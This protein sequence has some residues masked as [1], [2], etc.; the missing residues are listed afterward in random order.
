MPCHV[1]YSMEP[2]LPFCSMI[3][4]QKKPAFRTGELGNCR[5]NSEFSG[6]K[7]DTE[8]DTNLWLGTKVAAPPTNPCEISGCQNCQFLTRPTLKKPI[9]SGINR[10][11]WTLRGKPFK[12]T[13]WSALS[14]S[15]LTFL[16]RVSTIFIHVA[17]DPN[18]S[19]FGGSW[20]LVRA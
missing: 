18:I 7:M 12:S 2:I 8:Q 11:V 16:F 14:P 13:R 5:V 6:T 15:K 20:L 3:P 4:H 1:C 17:T 10:W 19:Q 9:A